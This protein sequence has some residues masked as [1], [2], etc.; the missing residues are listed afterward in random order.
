M[1]GCS[2]SLRGRRDKCTWPKDI[3]PDPPAVKNF[4][5]GLNLLTARDPC[6]AYSRNVECAGEASDCRKPYRSP[7][8]AREPRRFHS[9]YQGATMQGLAQRNHHNAQR[10][11]HMILRVVMKVYIRNMCSRAV[12]AKIPYDLQSLVF[13]VGQGDG[14]SLVLRGYISSE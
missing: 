4:L 7:T 10:Q 9:S 1:V 11:R 14:L 2:E 5:K 13:I 3:H 6:V 12:L 8:P